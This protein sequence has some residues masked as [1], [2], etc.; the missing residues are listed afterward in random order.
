MIW[1]YRI[2]I[3][4]LVLGGIF[5]SGYF[6]GRQHGREAAFKAAVAAYQARERINHET[7]ALNPVALC[8][9]LGGMPEQCAALLRRLDETTTDQ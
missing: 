7:E 1:P 3:A 5:T 6:A 2:G 8:R 9:A 4:A